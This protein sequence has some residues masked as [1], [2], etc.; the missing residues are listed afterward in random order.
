MEIAIRLTTAP[1]AKPGPENLGFGR[2]FTDHMFIMDYGPS[3]GWH[4]PRIVPYGP[5]SL[6]PAAA[7]FHYAQAVFEGMKAFRT[8][9]GRVAL[10]RPRLNIERLNRSCDRMCIPALDPDF[11]LQA[12]KTLVDVERDWVPSAPGTALYIRPFIF[13]C[14]TV[15]GV[16]PAQTYKFLI[17]LSPVGSYYAQ[18]MNPVSIYVEPEYVRA[19]RGGTGEAKA[20]GN[21][22]AGLKAQQTAVAEG[23]AQ[24]LWL[25][26]LER[27]YVEEVG[28][29]NV[30]FR[31]DDE[32]ATP[33][34]S[35]S[36]LPG[37]VRRSVLE[38]LRSWGVPAVERKITIDEVYTAHAEGRLKEAFGTGT[39][40]VISPIGQLAW[41]NNVISINGGQIGEL[42]RQLY[43]TL[44]GIQT[45]RLPDEFG[46]L[47]EV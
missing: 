1:K 7:V 30:F 27:R 41:R 38:L 21:Y 32:V 18:G 12:I 23:H 42:A 17:I 22:A 25:D 28:A 46:W 47:E 9:D 33:E 10:F 8:V 40:A 20:A 14:D 19:V 44:T 35:G 31:F 2:V 15:L 26:A 39:A 3:Q 11:V 29:M 24:V 4:D 34:L 13:A 16:H 37:I 6:E 36:I 45:G 43:D 5:L